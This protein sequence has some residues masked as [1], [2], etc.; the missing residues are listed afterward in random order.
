MP[1]IL[2]F[3][4][5]SNISSPLNVLVMHKLKLSTP[6]M[7]LHLTRRFHVVVDDTI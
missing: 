6:I 2:T 4:F 1:L 7:I 3:A 5:N